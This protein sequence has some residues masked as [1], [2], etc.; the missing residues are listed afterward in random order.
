MFNALNRSM[1]V[2]KKNNINDFFLRSKDKKI[3]VK[4]FM[5]TDLFKSISI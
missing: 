4:G 1:A 3:T 5:M 2:L